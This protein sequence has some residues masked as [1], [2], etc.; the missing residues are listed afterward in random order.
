MEHD[1]GAHGSEHS[2][3]AIAT[4][5]LAK[6][7]AYA[8]Q[9]IDMDGQPGTP[10]PFLCEVIKLVLKRGEEGRLGRVPRAASDRYQK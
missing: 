3:S 7:A 4:T 2:L 1:A 6:A 8:P 9:S 5:E 10:F